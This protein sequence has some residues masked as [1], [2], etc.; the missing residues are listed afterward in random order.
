[1]K[2]CLETTIPPG[3]GV[4]FKR[5]FSFFPYQDLK[6]AFVETKYPKEAIKYVC[7]SVLPSAPWWR[8]Q[9]PLTAHK[10]FQG[11]FVETIYL[12]GAVK[13]VCLSDLPPAPWWDKQPPIAAHK[14]LQGA[15]NESV[16]LKKTYP[17][18]RLSPGR[19]PEL[20]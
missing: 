2:V 15:G 4:S 7:L 17:K 14:S 1:L 5:Q 3:S 13:Y 20:S 16:H 10:S 19:L 18:K 6:G 12:K 9:P 11:A 8:K